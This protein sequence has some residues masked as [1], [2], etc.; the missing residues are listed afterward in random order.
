MGHDIV[1]TPNLNALAEQSLLFEHGYVTSPLCR[2]SLASIVS[3]LH[4]HQHGVVGND[5]SPARKAERH[6][7]DRPVVEAFH[8]NPSLV[9]FLGDRG[10]LSFQSGKWWE[11]SWQ[12]GGFTHGMTHGD[13]IKGGRHGD[14]GLQIGRKGMAPIE[15]FLDTAQR[16]EKPFFVWYAPFLPHTPHNP[17][18]DILEHYADLGLSAPTAKYYAMCEWF[19][20]TCGELIASLDRRGIRENT[21]IVYLCDNGWLAAADSK[22]PLPKGW[23]PG[24]A[25]K[26]KGSP[27]E[28]GIRTPIFF[29]LPGKIK[30]RRAEGMAS[31]LDLFTTI[32]PLCGF[33]PPGELPGIDLTKT[34]RDEVAGAAYSIHNM[35]PDAPFET[36][37]YTWLRQGPWKF[38]SRHPGIDTT[39][40]LTVHD[41]DRVPTQLF[42]LDQDPDETTNLAE[43]HPDLVTQFQRT[44]NATFP[45]PKTQP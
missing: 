13:P 12:D 25:P 10:Y 44:L 30:P 18:A 19:D 29:S 21:L 16:E 34:Q 31:S 28:L 20:A 45:Q 41:W 14:L 27:Y 3:G 4:P 37:Q 36:L 11:G 15:E 1:R 42:N 43:D 24:Y 39:R 2:P 9:R 5:V 17:P 7:E 40:Y 38:L 32:A 35:V 33:E 23:W 22:I 26:S 6:A 8:Q